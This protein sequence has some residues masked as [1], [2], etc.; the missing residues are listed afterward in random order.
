MKIIVDAFGGDNAPGEILLGCAQARK[1]WVWTGPH[2]GQGKLLA[3]AKELG[4]E[5]DLA[6]MEILDCPGVLT[7]EDE[8]TAV[9]KEKADSSMA[10]GLRA[11]AEGKGD[12][13]ASAGNSGAL[14]VGATMIVKR[15][16]GV[17]RVAFAPLL[18]MSQGFFMLSDGGASVDCRP[19]MLLQFGLMGAAYM[20][21]VMGVENPRVG[22]V[23]VGTE[24]HRGT[25]CATR[26]TNCSVRGRT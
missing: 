20:R 25:S 15:I 26:P 9:L 7:M 22:L 12:A 10:V 5:T 11:L 1:S 2:R 16:K 23:N 13:F 3:C 19:E 18:P 21:D 17:K 14:V 24:S 6:G 4:L 8:P